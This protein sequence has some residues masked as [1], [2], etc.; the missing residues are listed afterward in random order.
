LYY[1]WR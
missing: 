1:I